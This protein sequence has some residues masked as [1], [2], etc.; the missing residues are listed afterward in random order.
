MEITQP[1]KKNEILP[2]VAMWMNIEKN[3][4]FS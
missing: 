1:Q 2:F 4:M 3:I